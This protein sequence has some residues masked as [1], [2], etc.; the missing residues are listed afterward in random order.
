[1]AIAMLIICPF[2]LFANDKVPAKLLTVSVKVKIEAGAEFQGSDT[3]SL[4]IASPL[5]FNA[6]PN[7]PYTEFQ[8]VRGRDSIYTFKV[9]VTDNWGKL[10]LYGLWPPD[11][12]RTRDDGQ[13]IRYRDLSEAIYWEPGDE[14]EITVYQR[15]GVMSTTDIKG[16]GAFKNHLYKEINN[17]LSAAVPERINFENAKGIVQSRINFA[18]KILDSN[19]TRLSQTAYHI[20]LAELLYSTYNS[21]FLSFAKLIDSEIKKSSST[22]GLARLRNIY[23]EVI[24]FRNVKISPEYLVYSRNYRAI[25]LSQRGYGIL[26]LELLLK[27]GEVSTDS[28]YYLIKKRFKGRLRDLLIASYFSPGRSLLPKDIAG[29]YDDALQVVKTPDCLSYI[30]AFKRLPGQKIKDFTFY[31]ADAKLVTSSGLAGK[32]VLIDVWYLG[33]VPCAFFYK[34]ILSRLEEKYHGDSN[35]VVLSVYWGTDEDWKKGLSSGRYT[36]EAA[37]NV[38][39]GENFKEDPFCQYYDINS[40]PTVILLDRSG[41]IL[42][43]NN[44]ELRRY[45]TLEKLILQAL[46]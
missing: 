29:I 25:L 44:Q 45:D 43:F 15:S 27:Y 18:K 24:S 28:M 30:K 38:S 21:P 32:I 40:A 9:P 13:D 22:G 10:R 8:S 1:M 11:R 12:I 33:C 36:S 42:N 20:L 4:F 14:L 5:S 16:K 34:D 31:D 3:L 23:N 37:L 35:F 19:R 6:E 17:A 2:S 46:K 7:A 39:V 41:T 26:E